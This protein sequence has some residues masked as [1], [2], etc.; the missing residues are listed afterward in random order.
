[1]ASVSISQTRQK[2]GVFRSVSNLSQLVSCSSASS[3][4]A[5]VSYCI[6]PR[7]PTHSITLQESP[8]WLVS[9]SRNDE[10]IANLAYLR[11]DDVDSPVLLREFA[12]IEAAYK[13]EREAR[14]GLGVKEAFLGES[15]VV[16]L[17]YRCS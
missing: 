4:F 2:S 5:Y 9:K 13:E 12:E 1:M 3:Q 7:S 17:E 6:H 8:R 11:K 14:V 10:A 15:Y 16:S